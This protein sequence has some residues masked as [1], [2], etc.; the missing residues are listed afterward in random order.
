MAF[1][2][3]EG[4]HLSDDQIAEWNT[5]L[6]ETI[7]CRCI[8]KALAKDIESPT[9]EEFKALEWTEIG[10]ITDE[11]VVG[12]AENEAIITDQDMSDF[13]LN[14]DI[15]YHVLHALKKQGA[16]IK[17]SVLPEWY[18]GYEV[19]IWHDPMRSVTI[20]KWERS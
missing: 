5:R 8:L 17:G 3:M 9:E 18:P 13:P 16:P 2:L 11:G 6:T 12:L 15:K 7:N 10:T 1:E 4:F 19:T 14:M 20:Y